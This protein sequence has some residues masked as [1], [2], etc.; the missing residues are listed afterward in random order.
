MVSK[1]SQRSRVV[2]ALPR[3]R[4]AKRFECEV[5]G[6]NALENR[7]L[8]V[9]ASAPTPPPSPSALTC[10]RASARSRRRA[11]AAKC[12]VGHLRRT[13]WPER[14]A[15]NASAPVP[16]SSRS[17]S[18]LTTRL[19]SSRRAARA[20]ASSSAWLTSSATRRSSAPLGGTVCQYARALLRL[21]WWSGWSSP[22]QPL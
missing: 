6:A 11:T 5:E 13:S 18:T 3:A 2:I 1:D 10:P 4:H 9:V 12:S 19:D 14:S 22:R 20:V 16:F 21:R 15:L 17:V 7:E 8:Q